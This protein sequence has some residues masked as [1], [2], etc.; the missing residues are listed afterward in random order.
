VRVSAL[1]ARSSAG[2]GTPAAS[3]RRS[4]HGLD[5][6]NFFLASV[7]TGFGPFLA[8]YL[9]ANSWTQTDIGLLLSIS[10]ALAL[11]GQFPAGAIIDATANVRRLMALAIFCVAASATFIAIHS[12]FASVL[13]SQL[14]HVVASCLLGPGIAALSLGIVGHENLGTRLGRNARFASVGAGLAAAIMGAIGGWLSTSAVFFVTA[15]LAGPAM[16]ALAHINE[17]VIDPNTAHG[18]IPVDS[19]PPRPVR[20]RTVLL[21]RSLLIFCA[22][23]LFFHL[24]NSAILPLMAGIVTMRASHSAAVLIAACMVVPQLVVAAL[25]PWV[26]RQAQERGR[27]WIF[28][29]GFAA[30]PVRAA[31]VAFVSD[32]YL[33]VALQV[34]DGLSGAVMGV[35]TALIV[36]DL[37]RNTGHFNAALGAIGTATGLGATLSPALAGVIADHAGATSAFLSLAAIALIGL[38]LTWLFLPETKPTR[39]A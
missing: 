5:W 28:L 33:L 1:A 6:L 38:V 30:L 12:S 10:G 29:I 14:L 3:V 13:A 9:T 8:V 23:L 20:I 37:T 18:G 36:A 4:L 31:A 35:L 26:G 19:N 21:N 11:L 2:A 7:Q 22:C 34:L 15:L 24:A 16:A 25:S 32:P 27:R 17:R 39:A